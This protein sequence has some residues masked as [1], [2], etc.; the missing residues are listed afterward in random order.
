[1]KRLEL[2]VQGVDEPSFRCVVC[3]WSRP[4]RAVIV[5]ERRHTYIGAAFFGAIG[6]LLCLGGSWTW[7][8]LGAIPVL[9]AVI[10]LVAGA[11]HGSDLKRLEREAALLR[12][13]SDGP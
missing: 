9:V 5:D 11:S 4:A 1:M 6:G 12:E 8:L 7:Y 3:G 2:V 10:G 13:M